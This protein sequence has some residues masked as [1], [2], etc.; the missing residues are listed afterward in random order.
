VLGPSHI[1]HSL[2]AEDESF[3]TGQKCSHETLD[4]IKGCPG[5]E[6]RGE[7]KFQ[8]GANYYSEDWLGKTWVEQQRG[9]RKIKERQFR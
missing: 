8:S 9:A 2:L 5:S 4:R 6:L 1:A 7:G 3:T